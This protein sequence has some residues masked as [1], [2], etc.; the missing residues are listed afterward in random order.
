MASVRPVCIGDGPPGSDLCYVQHIQRFM[1]DTSERAP[2]ESSIHALCSA[3]A[4]DLQVAT[5][6]GINVADDEHAVAINMLAEARKVPSS[7]QTQWSAV[8]V[9]VYVPNAFNVVR[10]SWVQ[11]KML[12]CVSI[13]PTS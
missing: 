5:V 12:R 13:R 7:P 4:A 2:L 3:L 1:W 10:I 8:V 9:A 11:S 6:M